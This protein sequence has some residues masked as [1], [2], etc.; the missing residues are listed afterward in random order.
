MNTIPPARIPFLPAAYSAPVASRSLA[1]LPSC[2]VN[3]LIVACVWL[4]HDAVVPRSVYRL[5][6]RE[7]QFRFRF[8]GSSCRRA[9]IA[10]AFVDNWLLKGTPMANSVFFTATQRTVSGL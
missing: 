7:T 6:H 3:K 10:I 1:A 2:A 4:V 5:K 8:N 9:E